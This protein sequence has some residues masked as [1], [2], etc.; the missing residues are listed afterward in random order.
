MRQVLS[1]LECV[2]MPNGQMRVAE[3][4][5]ILCGSP[6]SAPE[7]LPPGLD[8]DSEGR[9][10]ALFP[11]VLFVILFLIGSLMG[12][13]WGFICPGV[14]RVDPMVL[15]SFVSLYGEYRRAVYLAI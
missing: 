10:E 13:L 6:Y 4:R 8:G 15:Q 5:D 14:R 1:I 2:E 9:W 7:N 11:L 12:M 3:R